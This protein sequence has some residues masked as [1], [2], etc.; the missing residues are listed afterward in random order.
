MSDQQIVETLQALN[1]LGITSS[2]V[3]V[4]KARQSGL[5]TSLES[6]GIIRWM[7]DQGGLSRD[8]FRVLVWSAPR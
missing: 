3:G 7:H 2:P 8:W 4:L 6:R 1:D 5:L